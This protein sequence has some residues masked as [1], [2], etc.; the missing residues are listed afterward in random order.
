[1]IYQLCQFCLQDQDFLT[2]TKL[3]VNFTTYFFLFS[4]TNELLS[5]LF[6]FLALHILYNRLPQSHAFFFKR[7]LCSFN[8][9][10]CKKGIKNMR[11]ESTGA[12]LSYYSS[13]SHKSLSVLDIF[14]YYPSILPARSGLPDKDKTVRE[15]YNL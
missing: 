4:V 5:Y 11:I 14:Y 15:F 8:N 10:R 6:I 2:K 7:S 13:L 3:F 1:M 9:N 12:I